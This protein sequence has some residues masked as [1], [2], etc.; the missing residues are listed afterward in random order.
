[1]LKSV[2]VVLFLDTRPEKP[3]QREAF[4]NYMKNGGAW[5]GFHFAAFALD[6]SAYPQN[7]DWYHNQFL[8][9]GQYEGNTWR[10]TSA[11]LKMEKKGH[12]SLKKLEKEFTTAPNEWYSWEHDLRQ[13]PD[14][15]ILLAISEKS[16]PLGTGPKI[17]KFGI[18]D[19]IL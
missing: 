10:P 9:A 15:E 14:I 2:D 3:A 6:K 18:V 4:E 19:I 12:P 8:G 13:N 16:Y 1:V 5:L 17:M 11:I 7:W